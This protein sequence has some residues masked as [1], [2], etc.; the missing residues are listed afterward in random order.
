MSHEINPYESPQVASDRM[1][2]CGLF[3]VAAGRI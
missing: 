3:C 1:A 2:I